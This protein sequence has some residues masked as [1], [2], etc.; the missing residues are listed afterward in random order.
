MQKDL[1]NIT[2]FTCYKFQYARKGDIQFTNGMEDQGESSLV[3]NSSRL[4]GFLGALAIKNQSECSCVHVHSLT[5][6][7]YVCVQNNCGRSSGLNQNWEPQTNLVGLMN[8]YCSGLKESDF[9]CVLFHARRP[10]LAEILQTW[11]RKQIHTLPIPH[12]IYE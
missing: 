9:S 6:V 1:L 10:A 3:A 2:Y 11:S 5:Q 8:L 4:R 12:Q 7:M